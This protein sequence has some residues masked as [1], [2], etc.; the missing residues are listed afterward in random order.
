MRPGLPW[1]VKTYPKDRYISSFVFAKPQEIS[2]D[3]DKGD[4]KE[5]HLH[6]WVCMN[7]LYMHILLCIL[8][9][10][11]NYDM[12]DFITV[13]EIPDFNEQISIIFS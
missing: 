6:T 10:S 4:G 2:L 9:Y 7:Y 12:D 8:D 1:A 3:P 11:F 13:T 5:V